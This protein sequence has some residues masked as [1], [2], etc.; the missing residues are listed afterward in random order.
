M[1]SFELL[2]KFI[3]Q[4][5]DLVDLLLQAGLFL[6]DQSAQVTVCL[7]LQSLQFVEFLGQMVDRGISLLRELVD[8]L[9]EFRIVA[10][11]TST[12]T[13]LFVNLRDL[14]IRVNARFNQGISRLFSDRRLDVLQS[15]ARFKELLIFR[16]FPVG[17]RFDLFEFAL[18]AV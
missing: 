7:F 14:L 13:N 12:S 3:R 10:T 2:R 8:N 18:E 16:N 1:Q 5:L 9:R 17:V 4:G 15:W 6:I 11:A